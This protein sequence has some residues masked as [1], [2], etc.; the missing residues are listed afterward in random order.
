MKVLDPTF[1]GDPS[2][3]SLANRL[4]TLN[5]TVVGIISNGKQGTAPFFTALQRELTEHCG[6]S[7]VVQ[8]TK[9]NYSAPAEQEIFDSAPRWNAL[10]AGI[11]D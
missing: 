7:Q 5:G 10:I 6:V 8:V 4:D 1:G 11:G 2:D 3:F 9:A